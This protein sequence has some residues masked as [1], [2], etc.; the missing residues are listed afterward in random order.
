MKLT[1]LTIVLFFVSCDP[2][3]LGKK[4]FI[5]WCNSNLTETK[6]FNQLKIDARILPEEYFVASDNRERNTGLTQNIYASVKFYQKDGEESLFGK[7]NSKEFQDRLNY[8]VENAKKDFQLVSNQDTFSP[9]LYHFERYY[10]LANFSIVNLVFEV[11]RKNYYQSNSL[12]YNDQIFNIG[13]IAFSFD[14]FN[15][16]IP[17]LIEN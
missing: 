13:K 16:E 15:S 12:V 2:D 14:H 7:Y 11:P 1:Y 5:T 10:N 8:F 9:Q 6:E 3:K 17:Q 4:E